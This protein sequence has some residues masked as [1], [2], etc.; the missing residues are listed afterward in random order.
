MVLSA[1]AFAIMNM[2]VKYLDAIPTF[3]LLFFR[4]LGTFLLCSFFIS[5]NKIPFWGTNKT[6]L[7]G[8]AITGTIALT[9]YFYAV[10][11]MPLAS[12]TTLRYLAPI[13]GVVLAIF[14]LKEK[15]RWYQFAFLSLA[16]IGAALIKGFD[17]RITLTGLTVVLS[18]AFFLGF[19]F[20]IIRKIGKSEHHL[21]VINYFMLAC[22]T[23]G[24]IGMTTEYRAPTNNEWM[25]LISLGVIGYLG[26][27]FMTQAFQIEETNKVAP[28]KYLEA[29]FV[30]VLSFIWFEERYEW[31]A[32]FGMLLIMIGISLNSLLGNKLK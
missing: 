11:I 21:V 5:K 20:V 31:M 26:Q 19:V 10:K 18:S 25:L 16:V 4:G 14:L 30:L 23:F 9:L 22:M 12:A 7:I 24:L 29:V 32:I 6:L 1:L 13:F 3:Q 8:R 27:V 28:L 17:S 15:V 2:V